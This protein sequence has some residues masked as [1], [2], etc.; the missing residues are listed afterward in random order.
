MVGIPSTMIAGCMTVF[1]L[2]EGLLAEDEREESY[3]R[4]WADHDGG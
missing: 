2:V 3:E 4:R 1:P